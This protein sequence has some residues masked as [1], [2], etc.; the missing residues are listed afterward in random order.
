MSHHSQDYE[1]AAADL[2]EYYG[3]PIFYYDPANSEP[4][5]VEASVFPERTERRKR[6][7]NGG[8][9]KVQMRDVYFDTQL[10]CAP[11]LNALVTIG[12]SVDQ[13]S[14]DEIGAAVGNRTKLGLRRVT[15]GEIS[16]PRSRG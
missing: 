8:W 13:Y 1:S 11:K 14:I 7:D 3:Q 16:R 12:T 2:V 9:D 15:V 6:F 10:I 5:E 4:I